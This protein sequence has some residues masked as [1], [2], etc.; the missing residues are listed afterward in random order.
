MVIPRAMTREKGLKN[1]VAGRRTL[2][3]HTVT[4]LGFVV[5]L[6]LNVNRSFNFELYFIIFIRENIFQS[7]SN[8]VMSLKIVINLVYY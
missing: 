3:E 8:E 1:Q 2:R 4:E 5:L 6:S 7:S